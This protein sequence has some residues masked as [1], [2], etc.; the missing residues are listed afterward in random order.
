MVEVFVDS[1]NVDAPGNF[2][3]SIGWN[4]REYMILRRSRSDAM[5]HRSEREVERR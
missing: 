3:G 2:L 1:C 4:Q 5:L